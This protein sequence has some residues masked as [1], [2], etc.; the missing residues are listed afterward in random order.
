MI[1]NTYWKFQSNTSSGYLENASMHK[2]FNTDAWVTRIA[3][4]IRRIDEQKIILELKSK[5][6]FKNRWWIP[7]Q[8]YLG[9]WIIYV[10]K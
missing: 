6:I 5:N 3:L 9:N 2:N 10:M 7:G 4:I 1:R 8:D